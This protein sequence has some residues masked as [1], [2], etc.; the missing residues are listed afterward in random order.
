MKKSRF[1]IA[2]LDLD[3]EIF[4]VYIA[5]FINSDLDLRIGFF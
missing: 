5:S 4:V 2:A 3:N 1:A